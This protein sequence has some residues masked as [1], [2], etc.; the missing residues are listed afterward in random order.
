[1]EVKDLK[2][3]ATI[4]VGR[5]PNGISVMPWRRSG[6]G[7]ARGSPA[8]SPE[9]RGSLVGGALLPALPARLTDCL[10]ASLAPRFFR[11]DVDPRGVC[12]AREG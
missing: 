4:P 7:P 6:V 11:Q 12:P 8:L 10:R 5:G 2:V 3:V 9:A 1:M